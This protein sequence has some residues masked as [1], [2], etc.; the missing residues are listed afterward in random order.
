MGI[1]VSMFQS[2]NQLLLYLLANEI[3]FSQYS[4]PFMPRLIS[5]DILNGLED[6]ITDIFIHSFYIKMIFP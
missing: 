4:G 3:R 1:F 6:T 5:K 2:K